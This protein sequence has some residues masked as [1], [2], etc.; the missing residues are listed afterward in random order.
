MSRDRIDVELKRRLDFE[1]AWRSGTKIQCE[2]GVYGWHKPGG[3]LWRAAPDEIVSVKAPSA[4]L[5]QDLA[6]QKLVF[7][8][9]T[10]RGTITTL[11]L[12][13]LEFYFG[14]GVQFP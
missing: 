7:S 13:N 9:D 4:M 14:T 6:V 8:Q 10:N 12:V 5:G 1:K 3:G 2:I 11:Q